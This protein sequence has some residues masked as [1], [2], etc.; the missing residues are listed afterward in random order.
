MLISDAENKHRVS[1]H[2]KKMPCV[3]KTNEIKSAI[4]IL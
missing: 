1:A 4:D 3:L 2:T